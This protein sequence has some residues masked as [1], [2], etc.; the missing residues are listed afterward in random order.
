LRRLT[1]ARLAAGVGFVVL[2]AALLRGASPPAVS[3]ASPLPATAAIDL[4]FD[5]VRFPTNLAF[6]PDGRI[7]Y[8]ELWGAVRV[9]ANGQIQSQVFFSDPTLVTDAEA[10]MLGL[11]LDR[12]FTSNGYVYVA[13][14][15]YLPGRQGD[16]NAIRNRLLRLR[17]DHGVGVEPKVLLDDIP[18]AKNY[19]NGGKLVVGP[20]NTLYLSVGSLASEKDVAQDMSSLN[21]K[22][23]RMNPD[24]SIPADNPFPGSPIYALGVR[25][26]YGLTIDPTTHDLWATD[27]GTE[28]DDK[29]IRVPAGGNLGWSNT[30]TCGVQVP[31]SIAPIHRWDPDIG[32]TGLAFVCSSVF[33]D[34][35]DR[36]LVG[37]TNLSALL[38]FAL[39]ADHQQILSIDS[40]YSVPDGVFVIDVTAAP[41]GAVYFTTQTAIYRLHPRVQQSLRDHSLIAQVFQLFV[42][43]AL[44]PDVHASC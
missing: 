5:G 37:N 22:I 24:G 39:S 32:V 23:L 6:A 10:G 41:D 29:L 20:D 31:G 16:D 21:G 4:A 26:V 19:A 12:N 25:N 38:V 44:T 18:G 42:P 8:T 1:P 33:P 11:A 2:L 36:L 34:L 17:D 3:A 9:I 30:D 35:R 13:Y 15:S 7:F 14:T 43:A 28:C 40:L 27:N